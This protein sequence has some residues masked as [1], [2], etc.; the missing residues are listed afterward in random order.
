[1]TLK[2][3][4]NKFLKLPLWKQILI[5]IV[6]IALIPITLI[7]VYCWGRSSGGGS[8][9]GNELE[10]TLV[11]QADREIKD[12]IKDTK[13]KIQNNDKTTKLIRERQEK[14]EEKIG[15]TNEEASSIN[16]DINSANTTSDLERLRQRIGDLK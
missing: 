9:I 1:M 6:A 12:D 14:I 4:K 8:N 7:V 3:L 5:V 13:E 2:Q 16:S 10:E 11:E 15:E